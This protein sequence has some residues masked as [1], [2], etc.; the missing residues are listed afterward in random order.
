MSDN[1]ITTGSVERALPPILAGKA[2][3]VERERVAD[4]YTGVAELFEAWVAR[5][6]SPHTQRAYRLD[7]LSLVAFLGLQWP[8]DATELL[9]V[10]VKD[11]QGWRDVMLEQDKAG[12]TINRRI[13][14]VSS[15]YKF[16][17]AAAAELRLP[18]T[19]PNPAHAQF[20]SR[21]STDARDET[22][23]LS[24]P[25]ARQ[26]LSLP[27]GDSVL[28][29]RDRAILATYLYTGIRLA[30]GCRL[31]V[32]DF[33]Q[34]SDDATLRIHEKGDKRRTIGIHVKAA[35]AIAEYLEAAEI[36]SG[37]L[38]RPRLNPRS[39]KLASRAMD[40]TTMYRLLMSYLE[41]IPSGIVEQQRP[42]GSTKRICIYNPHSLRATAATLLLENSV[43]IRKVQELLG[44]AHITTTQVYDRRR[45]T[46][47]ES[48]SHDMPI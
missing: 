8:Q 33:H 39:K 15:F 3:L 41:Q 23:A 4:F 24:A 13:A 11:V 5:C 30:A 19:V 42:D 9:Q 6:R 1:E 10:T 37:P 40:E 45:R 32:S 36:T 21:S 43:D 7:V 44:H 16:L 46:T 12:K 2:T 28:A 48:A 35:Q 31:K 29:Y 47:K 26:L 18:I 25:R 34:D 38:F 20:I 22:K 17:Q 27:S 14:S